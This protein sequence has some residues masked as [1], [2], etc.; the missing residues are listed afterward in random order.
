M[1]DFIMDFI[2]FIPFV[3]NV[4]FVSLFH[5]FHKTVIIGLC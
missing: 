3:F 2:S 4:Y 5:T 1:N